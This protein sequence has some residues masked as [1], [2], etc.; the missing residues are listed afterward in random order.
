MTIE[1]LQNRYMYFL[2]GILWLNLA[3]FPGKDEAQSQDLAPAEESADTPRQEETHLE[4]TNQ[5]T[6]TGSH[7][8]TSTK[9]NPDVE[10][11]PY[12]PVGDSS[13]GNGLAQ[14]PILPTKKD[15]QRPAKDSGKVDN[16]GKANELGNKIPGPD[17]ANSGIDN[18]R[19]AN[20]CQL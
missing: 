18:S 15:D 1:W 10:K 19:A 14:E 3:C 2:F 5:E 9:T 4:E 7:R 12:E 13:K 16:S 20:T 8:E 17:K 11:T 6:P